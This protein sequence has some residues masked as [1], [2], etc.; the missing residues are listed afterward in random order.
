MSRVIA[1]PLDVVPRSA[2]KSKTASAPRPFVNSRT[3]ATS[4]PS[5]LTKPS[6][7]QDSAKD[8]ARS[9]GSTTMISA[10]HIA[11]RTCIAM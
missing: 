11:L 2:T 5:A 4:L 3:F 1:K 9:D 7:P 8:K 10:A 6:T